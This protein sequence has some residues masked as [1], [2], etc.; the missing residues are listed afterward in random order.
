MKRFGGCKTTIASRKYVRYLG[1]R[2]T[3][4]SGYFSK[5]DGI[6]CL[7]MVVIKMKTDIFSSG[8]TDDKC[9]WTSMSGKWKVA[10]PFG[11]EC[12]VIGIKMSERANS[13]GFGGYQIRR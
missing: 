9:S 13:F 10:L 4:Q 3:F 11:A 7:A 8:R 12:A 1:K 2:S 5:F 6:I